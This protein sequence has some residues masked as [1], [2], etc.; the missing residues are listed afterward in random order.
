MRRSSTGKA[1]AQQESL[2]LTLWAKG[3]LRLWSERRAW[4]ELCCRNMSL[5]ALL[6]GLV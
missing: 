5:T 6:N 2:D 3:A 1:E 4:P